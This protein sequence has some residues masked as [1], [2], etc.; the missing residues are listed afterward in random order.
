MSITV[1]ES[2]DGQSA[3]ESAGVVTCRRSFRVQ[4]DAPSEYGALQALYATGI[5]ARGDAYPAAPTGKAT[6][7]CSGKSATPADNTRT[8]FRVDVDYTNEARVIE[9]MQRD[10]PDVAPWSRDPRHEYEF[11]EYNVP[12]QIDFTTPTAKP[13]VNAAGEPFDPP[14]EVQAVYPKVSISRASQTYDQ[15]VAA[16]L[17]GSV[18]ASD[19]TINGKVVT[20]GTARLLRWSGSEAVWLNPATSAAVDYYE[21]AIE[22]EIRSGGFDVSLRNEG[23]HVLADGVQSRI[24]FSDGQPPAVPQFLSADGTTITAT[25]NYITFRPYEHK[26]WSAIGLA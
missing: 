10:D 26:S 20:A 24:I 3:T 6:P 12:L 21:E 18:N 1:S 17:I 13:L 11:S 22:I 9:Q 8:I 15:N 19:V 2:I 25:P 16:A 7:K 5:P 23:F 4:L 14:L